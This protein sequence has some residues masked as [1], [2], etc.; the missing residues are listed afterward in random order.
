MNEVVAVVVTYNRKELLVQNLDALLSQKD[1]GLDII[2]VDNASTDGTFEALSPYLEKDNIT[3][4]NTGKNLGGAGG[5][6]VGMKLAG[7]KPYKYCWL[8]DDDTIPT[9]T[10][11][12]SLVNKANLLSNEFSFLCSLVKF[13]DDELAFMNGPT[14]M[15]GWVDH[16]EKICKNNL[17]PVE[18]CSFVAC[19]VNMLYAKKVGLPVKE[20]FIYGDDLEYTLRLSKEK[21]A[22]WDMDSVVFHKMPSNENTTRVEETSAARIGRIFYTYRNRMFIYK[23]MGA[24]ATVKYILKYFLSIIRILAKSKDYKLKRIWVMTR[25]LV[26]GIFFNPKIER[27]ENE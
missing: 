11:L 22:Y 26:C 17:V 20:F 19:F 15:E 5:F 10:A 1:T 25:G 13:S 24:K 14:I 12:S 6:N 23:K 21:I 2:I 18:S 4:H 7:E 27:Y 16:H 8:M 9:E 3:Y